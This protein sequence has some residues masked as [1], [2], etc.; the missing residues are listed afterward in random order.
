MKKILVILASA[1][2]LAT[3]GCNQ[4]PA[5]AAGDDPTAP[6]APQ[7]PAA[8][9]APAAPAPATGAPATAPLAGVWE[10]VGD[11]G[12]VG[13]RFTAASGGTS[14]TIGCDGGTGRVFI[15]WALTSGTSDRGLSINANGQTVSFDAVF[16]N[17]GAPM[18]SV[19]VAG[20][21]P[22]LAALSARQP[23]LAVAAA[24]QVVILPWSPSIATH[25]AA[26]KG[27]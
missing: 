25:L 8:E 11:G 9:A 17:D 10:D 2:A 5:P 6:A 26:C 16:S 18:L 21:D 13:A 7:A 19:D 14:M 24:G 1:T 22:R 4:Q 15:N 12:T 27:G 23:D 3:S 20:D